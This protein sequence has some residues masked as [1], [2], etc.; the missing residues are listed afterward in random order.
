MGRGFIVG[1]CIVP[2]IRTAKAHSDFDSA[3]VSQWLTKPNH[4]EAFRLAVTRQGVAPLLPVNQ[5]AALAKEILDYVAMLNNGRKFG[6]EVELTPEL[7]RQQVVARLIDA[8]RFWYHENRRATEEAR[9]RD[10]VI[11]AQGLRDDFRRALGKLLNSGE[12]IAK[13][14]TGVEKDKVGWVFGD[15]QFCHFVEIAKDV[16]DRVDQVVNHPGSQTATPGG[17]RPAGSRATIRPR[18]R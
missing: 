8:K 3:G 5:Q 18:A 14:A 13:L 7:I 15:R 10:P 4:V 9:R 2:S 11:K 6:K 17:S 16:I 12:A 1:V